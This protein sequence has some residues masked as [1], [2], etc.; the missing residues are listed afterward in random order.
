MAQQQQQLH[1]SLAAAVLHGGATR[2]LSGCTR[3]GDGVFVGRQMKWGG[4]EEWA[5]R[6]ERCRCAAV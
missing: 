6:R 4:K 5:G 3:F 1:I 2:V